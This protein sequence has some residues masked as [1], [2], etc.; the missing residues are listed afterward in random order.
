MQPYSLLRFPSSEVARTSIH[1]NQTRLS[2]VSA[3]SATST[4]S[5]IPAKA[6]V[7]PLFVEIARPSSLASRL[8]LIPDCST[9]VELAP[10]RRRWP[11]GVEVWENFISHNEES[12]LIEMMHKVGGWEED[13]VAKRLSVSPKFQHVYC[14]SSADLPCAITLRSTLALTSTTPPIPQGPLS[15][16]CL[17]K[18]APLSR[19]FR[20]WTTKSPADGS[21]SP[22][23]QIR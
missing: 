20:T 12:M 18:L 5:F 21:A 17:W 16:R 7:K 4:S 2:Q 1:L 3:P 6:P 19:H 14:T 9:A 10:G 22:S 8:P 15:G 23:R 13:D 11:C